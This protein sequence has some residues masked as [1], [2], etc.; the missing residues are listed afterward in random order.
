M[1][2]KL[3]DTPEWNNVPE[4]IQ[5]YLGFVYIITHKTSGKYYVG[6]KQFWKAIRRKPLKGQKRVRLDRVQSDWKNY[7]GSSKKFLEFCKEHN[8]AGFKRE[9]V[10]LSTNKFDLSYFELKQQLIHDVL[11]DTNSFNGIINV[12]LSRKK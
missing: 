2:E 7:W 8:F 11:F 4:N 9:I 3:P 12:R 1:P 6:K 10:L 5:E